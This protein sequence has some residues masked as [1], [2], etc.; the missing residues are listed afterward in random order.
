M[1]MKPEKHANGKSFLTTKGN[2]INDIA[3]LM[4]V[5]SKNNNK[6]NTKKCEEAFFIVL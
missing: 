3:S 6:R 4:S 5:L 1:T 2:R